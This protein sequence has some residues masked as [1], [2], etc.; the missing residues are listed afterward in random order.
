MK[1]YYPWL[2]LEDGSFLPAV[3]CRNSTENIL[4]Y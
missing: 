1:Q 2:E 4:P 3:L